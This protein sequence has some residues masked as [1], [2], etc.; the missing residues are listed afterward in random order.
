MS[1]EQFLIA[2]GWSFGSLLLLLM[3]SGFFSGTETALFSL[4]RGELDRLARSENRFHR[5]VASLMDRPQQILN[6][7]LLGNMLVN[8]GFA[9]V[10]AIIVL[11][12]EHAGAPAYAVVIASVVPLL[13]LILG[14]EVIPKMIAYVLGSAWAI[15]GSTPMR[16]FR[17]AFG[18]V[19]WI[20]ERGFVWPLTCVFATPGSD[21][22]EITADELDGVLDLSARRGVLDQGANELLQEILELTDLHVSNVMVPRVD[23]IAFDVD[24]PR[25]SL[26][27]LFRKTHLRKIPV[28]DGDIDHIIGVVHAKHLFLSP[29]RSL[30]ELATRVSYVP[31]GANL[32]RLLF[33]FRQARAQMAIVVDEYGGTGGLVTL[34]DVLEE[35]VGDIPQQHDIDRGGAVRRCGDRE[36]VLDGNLPIHE[37]CEG[38]GMDLGGKRISTIAG[39]VTQLLGRIPRV[40]DVVTYRNLRFTVLR[41][42][43]HR[44]GELR[45]E[46]LEEGK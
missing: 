35:I 29:D 37:W 41:M 7:I 12:M 40:G 4:T 39:F 16:F 6:T 13:V 20:L 38:F 2:H 5:A 36:Y 17:I 3:G 9:G 19:L 34:E 28:Y 23:M 22:P 14:G 46:L 31:E 26:G 24:S 21:P 8:V 1:W 33:H 15:P 25:H 27:A 32:E 42:H 10:S 45:L 18:P 43:R 30:R 44:L 11:D